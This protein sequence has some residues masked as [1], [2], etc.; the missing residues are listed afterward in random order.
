MIEAAL[1]RRTTFVCVDAERLAD[2]YCVV[3]GFTRHYDHALAVDARFPPTGAPDGAR[4]RLIILKAR[5][6]T[7][8]MLGFLQFEQELPGRVPAPADGRVRI[9]EPVLVFGTD[10]VHA[11]ASRAQRAGASISTPPSDW[12]VPSRDGDGVT[13]LRT[14]CFFDPEGHY[15]EVSQRL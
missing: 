1:L 12:E 13:R 4:A 3:F 15:C 14:L 8:G 5:D 2:F 7:V 11:L 6:P 9:R 10:D